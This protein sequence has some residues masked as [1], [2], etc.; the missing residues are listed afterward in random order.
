M[1]RTIGI[2]LL[3]AAIVAVPIAVLALTSGRTSG[4]D[5]QTSFRRSTKPVSTTSVTEWRNIPGLAE[6][7][8][9][10][11]GQV[12]ALFS[13]N[14]S[15]GLARFRV[16]YDDGPS[17]YPP[18]EFFQGGGD[19]QQS[20]ALRGF[21]FTFVG[22]AGTFEGRDGHAYTVQ[23]RG[24]GTLRGAVLDLLYQRGTHC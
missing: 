1:K 17:L 2:V 16:L 9:C 15:G 7:R 3:T 12:T 13:G 19:P 21:S 5:H 23:W 10:A 20:N 8:I 22:P 11:V 18:A 4:L 14:M 6:L 24:G